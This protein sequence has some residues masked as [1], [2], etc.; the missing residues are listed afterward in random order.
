MY[1]LPSIKWVVRLGE[2]MK[3]HRERMKCHPEAIIGNYYWKVT[4]DAVGIAHKQGAY[5]KILSRGPMSMFGDYSYYL[6]CLTHPDTEKIGKTTVYNW[7]Q[8]MGPD[9]EDAKGEGRIKDGFHVHLTPIK[10]WA[11]FNYQDVIHFLITGE[12]FV[13][14]HW[15][16]VEVV[17]FSNDPNQGY[18]RYKD[19]MIEVV[20]P[21]IDQYDAQAIHYLYWDEFFERNQ[22]LVIGIG[23]VCTACKCDY[24]MAEPVVD[25]ECW[26]CKNGY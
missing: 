19:D 2:R 20:L 9:W 22:P 16:E 8:H 17:G 3:C 25:F 5:Y 4:V 14:K 26:G 6:M 18:P 11:L 21:P 13:D 12:K 24:P 10:Q 23:T 7:V 1:V 15:G